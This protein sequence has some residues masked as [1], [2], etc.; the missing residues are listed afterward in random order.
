MQGW[1]PMYSPFSTS[2]S[3]RS[4]TWFSP[5]FISP[6]TLTEPGVMS[7]NF[8]IYSGAAKLRREEPISLER[9]LVLKCLSPGQHQQIKL[10]T[11]P[12]AQQQILADHR[13]QHPV[14]LLAGLH[15][16]GRLVI[17]ATVVDSQAVQQIVA[18]DFLLKPSGAVRGTSVYQFHS[19][20]PFLSCQKATAL[21][22]ATFRESTPW[23]MGIFTV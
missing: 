9:T 4:C 21:A 15:G 11:L 13:V 6:R 1:Q 14:D 22:A 3:M 7:R 10:R 8:S 12:V 18:A 5:S 20:H 2:S 23:Y 17:D 19:Y 16:H